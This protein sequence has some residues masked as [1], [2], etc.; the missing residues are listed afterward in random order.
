MPSPTSRTLPTSRTSWPEASPLISRVRTETI[1]SG[2]N[3]IAAPRQQLIANGLDPVP[4]RAVE[5]PVADLDDHPAQ[6]RL[7]HLGLNDR[8]EPRGPANGLLEMLGLLVGQ[9]DRRP[10]RHPD[11]L[12]PLV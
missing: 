5:H 2:L 11:P 12:G 4:D 10:D 1:S 9:R 8:V 7:V 6:Q 3:F